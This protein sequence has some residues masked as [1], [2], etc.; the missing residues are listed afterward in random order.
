MEIVHCL[1][2]SRPVGSAAH[3]TAHHA[4]CSFFLV[5]MLPFYFHIDSGSKSALWGLK[6]WPWRAAQATKTDGN[7]PANPSSS[8]PIITSLWPRAL[9]PK[10]PLPPSRLLPVLSRRERWCFPQPY[11]HFKDFPQNQSTWL[12]IRPVAGGTALSD[13][14]RLWKLRHWEAKQYFAAIQPNTGV[15]IPDP[16]SKLQWGVRQ[17]LTVTPWLHCNLGQ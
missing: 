13:S 16:T 4:E 7:P 3:I 10:P 15:S 8:Q 12:H 2:F 14:K 11:Y 1:L 9:L 5:H 6:H 17:G